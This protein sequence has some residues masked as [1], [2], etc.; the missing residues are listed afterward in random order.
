LSYLALIFL[1]PLLGAAIN[2]LFWRRIK[3][4]TTGYIAS[5]A[6]FISFA[7]TVVAFFKL[8]GM[9]ADSRIIHFTLYEWIGVGDFIV[10]LGFRLDPLSMTWTLVVTGV[11]FLTTFTPS[12]TC[13]ARRIMQN[14]GS[15]VI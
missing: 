14:Q 9:P 5:L 10:P 2:G 6:V 13:P 4:D 3:G 15:S 12:D 11:G 7:L 1:I 8:I